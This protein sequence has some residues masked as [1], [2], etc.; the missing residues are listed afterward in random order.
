MTTSHTLSRQSARPTTHRPHLPEPGER[1]RLREAWGLTPQQVA[2][3][4]GVRPTTVRSWES[5]RSTPTGKRREAYRR[6]LQGLAQH[7]DGRPRPTTPPARSA[8]GCAAPAQ[9]IPES[10][11]PADEGFTEAMSTERVPSE[12]LRSQEAGT[13]VSGAR[14]PTPRRADGAAEDGGRLLPRVGAVAVT[15]AAWVLVLA[16]LGAYLPAWDG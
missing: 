6:F 12:G 10:S 4:F 16:L 11:R 15:L 5:G 13:A 14:V 7:A 3:A 9:G 8:P 2:L 1:R